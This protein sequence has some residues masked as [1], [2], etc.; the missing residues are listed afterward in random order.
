MPASIDT[1]NTVEEN[2]IVGNANGIFIAPGVQGNTFRA[3]TIVG[4]PPV[5]VAVDHTDNMGYDV[6]NLADDGA[7]IFHDNI[8]LTAINAPCPALS[9]HPNSS[10]ADQLQF[11]GCATHPPAS[12]CRLTV[13]EWD[14][15]LTIK[16]S[17]GARPLGIGDRF[18]RMTVQQ[19]L[20]SRIAA[21]FGSSELPK[22]IKP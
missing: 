4:N 12:S 22:D 9:P 11:S 15:Y 20:Q 6:K 7:N 2:E 13:G 18:Q 1:D 10:I 5:Q 3:N 17:P 14:H 8:C 19:Y 21:G 16:V